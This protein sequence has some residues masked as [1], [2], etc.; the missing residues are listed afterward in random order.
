MSQIIDEIFNDVCLDERVPDGIFKLD[1]EEHMNALRDQ[2]VKRGLTLEDA[3]ELT[4]KMLEGKYPERQA[5][6]KK[7]GYTA[8]WPSA[9]LK[10]KAMAENPGKYIEPPKSEPEE[11]EEIEPAQPKK[12]PVAQPQ[13]EPA[14]RSVKQGGQALS[15]EPPRGTEKPESI[16]SPPV[17]V[18]PPMTP[19]R[20][21]AEKSIVQQIMQSDDI[22]T[23][24]QFNVPISEN[25]NKQLNTLRTIATSQGLTEA[26]E[27]LS[28]YI[29]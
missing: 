3:T 23:S 5:V 29:S 8:T 11:P 9:E 10:A 28:K 18:V 12:E 25:C 20:K 2:L 19:E 15:I 13:Q 16:P 22:S 4:N 26:I 14:P 7:S 1:E 6:I 21:A 24:S 17:P 27:F